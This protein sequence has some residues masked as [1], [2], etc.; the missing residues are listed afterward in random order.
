MLESNPDDVFLN[1]AMAMEHQGQND[2]VSA[3]ACFKQVLE[4]DKTHVPAYYQVGN[5]FMQQQQTADALHYLEE[6]MQQAKLKKD[7]KAVREIQALLDEL[8]Y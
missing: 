5:I 8:L 4:L 1:Y 7:N 6:G 2:W 3:L